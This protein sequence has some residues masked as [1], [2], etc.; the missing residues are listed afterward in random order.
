[1]LPTHVA[2]VPYEDGLVELPDLLHVAAALQ[3]Q[4]TRDFTPVWGTPALVSAFP[5]LDEVPPAYIPLVII[6][7][8]SLPQREHAFHTTMNGQAIGL[9]QKSDDW[10]FAASHELLETICDPQGGRK[11]SGPSMA[12]AADPLELDKWAKPYRRQG[13]VQY[14]LEVCDPCQGSYYMIDGVKVSDFVTPRYYVGGEPS[15]GSYSFTGALKKALDLL[16]GSYITWYT[17][18][19]N[20]P[21]WQAKTDEVGAL[22]IGPMTI[23]APGSS[24]HEVD[25]A[26]DLRANVTRPSRR[27]R[28]LR[29]ARPGKDAWRYGSEL[30]ADIADVL[31][32]I[33]P[34]AKE[35]QLADLVPLLKA[36]AEDKDKLWTRWS[37]SPEDRSKEL[38]ARFGRDFKYAGG[39]PS[40]QQFKVA[41][42]QAEQL[43]SREALMRVSG[44]FAMMQMQGQT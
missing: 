2:L 35:I 20:S 30:R 42:Q 33:Y 17:S 12:D 13:Q 6:P 34:A 37:K 44:Q 38:T 19:K 23:P 3:I 40:R 22:H 11:V 36:L 4:L 26:S 32:S 5:S 24:R 21:V 14:L 9:I 43:Q 18:I 29:K 28:R 25:Y 31:A 7:E 8:N 1:M 16:P 15:S 41:Y 39:F 10:S 27:P